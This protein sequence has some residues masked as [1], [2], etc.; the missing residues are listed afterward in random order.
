MLDGSFTVTTSCWRCP[1]HEEKWCTEKFHSDGNTSMETS[2]LHRVIRW[3]PASASA[4][5]EA[6]TRHFAMVLLDLGWEKS[7][8][9]VTLVDKRPKLEQLL[10]LAGTKPLNAEDTTLYRSVRMRVSSLGTAQT[11]H[12]L[13]SLWHEG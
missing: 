12:L 4:E 6:D 8:P 7:S 9:V 13:Q 1:T 11:C 5:L 3:D 10:L 2:F